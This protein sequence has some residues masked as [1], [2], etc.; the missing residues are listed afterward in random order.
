MKENEL[1]FNALGL[2]LHYLNQGQ[3]KKIYL[4]DIE[5]FTDTLLMLVNI[6]K[7]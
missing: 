2:S 6:G 3:E 7:N 4:E 1:K 5:Y